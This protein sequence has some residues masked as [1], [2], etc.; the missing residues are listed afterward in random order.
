VRLSGVELDAAT[1]D[2]MHRRFGR[3]L[4][5]FALHIERATVR[6][7]DVNGPRGGVDT[8]CRVKVVLSGKPSVVTE[9]KATNASAAFDRTV[10]SAERA[11]RRLIGRRKTAAPRATHPTKR[12]VEP[13]PPPAEGAPTS[14]NVKHRVSGMT[15]ALETSA[16]D[17]PSR[18]ST[19]KSVNRAKQ[20]SKL[21]RKAVTRARSPKRRATVAA[22]SK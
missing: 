13:P 8:A 10:D 4:G 21:R 22:V 17:R 16:K 3:K 1:R 2:R 5:K 15:S 18:K 11:V 14:M 7:Y 9:Q 6:L 12:R 20:G 19:R